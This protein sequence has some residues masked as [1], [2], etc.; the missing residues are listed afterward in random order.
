MTASLLPGRPSGVFHNAAKMFLR[1]HGIGED[2]TL[3]PS[4]EF[5]RHPDGP[6]R[7]VGLSALQGK[8]QLLLDLIKELLDRFRSLFHNAPFWPFIKQ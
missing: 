7:R 3:D 1:N 6:L 5:F 8:V 2:E 4:H